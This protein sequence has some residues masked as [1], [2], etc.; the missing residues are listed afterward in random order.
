MIVLFIVSK[1]A[2][3][4]HAFFKAIHV[5]ISLW[6]IEEKAFLR[7]Y[8]MFRVTEFVQLVKICFINGVDKHGLIGS[9]QK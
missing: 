8:A 6:L 5:S 7:V 2:F 3:K 1:H 9:H 4:I